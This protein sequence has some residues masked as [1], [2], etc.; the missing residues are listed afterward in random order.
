MPPQQFKA[1][2]GEPPS[3][4]I[5]KS[6][7][8]LPALLAERLIQEIMEGKLAPGSR[9]VETRLAEYHTVSRATV[10]EA[11]AQ[12]ERHHLVERVPRFGARVAAI[13]LGELTEL[14]EIRA[15]LLGLAASRAS[16]IGSEQDFKRMNTLAGKVVALAKAASTPAADFSQAVLVLQDLLLQIS[17]SKWLQTLYEQLSNQTLWRVMVRHHGGAYSTPQ[18]RLDSARDWRSLAETVQS[19]DAKASELA[20]RTLVAGTARF[21]HEQLSKASHGAGEMQSKT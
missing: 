3:D 17:G 10:R 14:F 2:S 8:S 16:A 21:V 4:S 1:T 18:R 15:M 20:A 6:A 13:G 11:L 12:L 7:Q 9:L 5:G 19:G